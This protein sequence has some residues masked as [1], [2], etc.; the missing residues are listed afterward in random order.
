MFFAEKLRWR[1]IRCWCPSANRSLFLT[2]LGLAFMMRSLFG[3]FVM[4]AEGSGWP[5]DV[6]NKPQAA[7]DEPIIARI[8][9]AIDFRDRVDVDSD[10]DV[11]VSLNDTKNADAILADVGALHRVMSLYVS[12]TDATDK[13]MLALAPLKDLRHLE[14][15]NNGRVTDTGYAVLAE[16]KS[17]K[18]LTLF[19]ESV[20]NQGMESL[21][22]LSKLTIL[23]L[24]VK[25]VT[26]KGLAPLAG[27]PALARVSLQGLAIRG[28][29]LAFLKT[30]PAVVSLRI[31]DS[32]LADAAIPNISGLQKLNDL[33]LVGTEVSDLGLKQLNA[34]PALRSLTLRDAKITSAGVRNLK[35]FPRLESLALGGNEISDAAASDLDEIT[36]LTFL[37]LGGTPITALTLQ[38]FQ[39]LRR[40]L[41]I[42]SLGGTS[43]D[44]RGATR[45]RP[46]FEAAFALPGRHEG[47]GRRRQAACAN[48]ESGNLGL[49]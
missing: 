45:A 48:P 29:G 40:R 14:L 39:N 19:S 30:S 22:R 3:G 11:H 49:A 46:F 41:T 43:I 35:Q 38:R 6:S 7:M 44:D 34:L 47:D 24:A 16:F 18:T 31:S 9:A 23:N 36:T 10:G 15:E 13:G 27:K 25:H 32:P 4:V 21:V 28:D 33:E 17:L 42:L 1:E 37:D 8:R 5:S 20:T 2:I 12:S 26:D